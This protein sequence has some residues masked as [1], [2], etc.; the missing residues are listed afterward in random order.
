MNRLIFVMIC[1]CCGFLWIRLLRCIWY[2]VSF[3]EWRRWLSRW[4][5]IFVM[6]C[7]VLKRRS[8]FFICWVWWVVVSCW[9]LS[10]WSNW[11]SVCCFI[12]WRVC[13][14]MNC[15]LGCL[16]MMRMV[17]FLRNSMVFCVVIWKVFWVCGLLS[18]CMNIMVIFVS[19]VWCVVI[20]WFCGR[21]V[22][23]RLSWVM[24]I[25]RIFCC[26][27]VRL[28]FVSLNSMCRMMLM[29]IVIWVVCVLWIRVCLNL[30]KCLRCWLRCCIC[31]WLLCRKVILRVLKVLVWF[32]LMVW[33]LCIW[34][35]W[36]GRCFVIIVI[37]R[38]CLIGFLLW[39][40]CIVCVCW[41]RLRFMRS[42]FV[43]CCLLRLCVYWVCWRWCCSFWCCCGCMSWR[44][45]V[46]FWRCRCMMVKI[47]R[48]LIWRWSCI[49]SIVIMWVWMK[50]W[51][52]CWFVLCLRFCCVCLIL[53]WVRLWWILC[54]WCMCLN[55]RLS[56]SSFCWKW[57]RS[58]CCLW[59]MCLCCVMWSL[60]VRR[61]RL[62]I[63]SCIWNMV[64]IFLIVMLC[65][66][67]FGFRIRNFVIMILVRVLI[68]LCW[69]WSWRRLRSW[70]GLVIWRIFVMR[71]WILC[72]VFGWWMLVRIL[73]GWVMKSCV[74]W[75]RRRC[76]WILRNCCWWFYLMLR[77][78]WRSSVSMRILWIGWLWRVICWSRWGCFV[79]GICVCVSC[80]DVCGIVFVWWV[81]M[82]VFRDV[83]CMMVDGMCGECFGVLIF[84]W[85][86][87]SVLLNYWL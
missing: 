86:I 59:R 15:C 37:M 24:R 65:M 22:L 35:S 5:C 9:L 57:S 12:C 62:C 20:C 26:W 30:L 77:V 56:V 66:W 78:W 2:F 3:M 34:M 70:L 16:I 39:R 61:F 64:R 53:I 6:L 76:F 4:L 46:C 73:C 19:F 82:G 54:I 42:W 45:W 79:I 8:R 50:G 43:I 85:E 87:G 27:L 58:I 32:C 14:L 29:F 63:L 60:L 44:I 13:L 75:L 33:F 68:V 48:I 49:R 83:V 10:V 74:L 69:M 36:N 25:I 81:C 72:C 67:I 11:W 28:I 40:C 52:V 51:L 17:W 21:L 7:K 23:W 31:C 71:L 38:C 47:W 18:V 80:Y 41:K 1:V 55:S 84:E